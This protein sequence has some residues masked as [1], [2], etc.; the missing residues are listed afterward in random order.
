MFSECGIIFPAACKYDRNILILYQ[1]AT[2]YIHT[3]A[4]L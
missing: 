2:A 3:E 1:Q 4:G